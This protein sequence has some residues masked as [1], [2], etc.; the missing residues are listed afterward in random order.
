MDESWSL[1]H[2]KWECLYHVVFI[3]KYR[4]KAL[5]SCP[6]V[7]ARGPRGSRACRLCLLEPRLRSRVV[8]GVA[9]GASQLSRGVRRRYAPDRLDRR[10]DRSGR[11][12]VPID[13]RRDRAAVHADSFRQRGGHTR[14]LPGEARRASSMSAGARD[15]DDRRRFALG[16]HRPPAGVQPSRARLHRQAREVAWKTTSS[17]KSDRPPAASIL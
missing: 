9:G 1:S 2:T 6:R 12:R 10:N 17:G 3:P 15:R 16:A 13:L 14:S 11:N 5:R 4:R 8:R 7:L